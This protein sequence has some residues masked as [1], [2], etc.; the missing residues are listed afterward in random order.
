MN[1]KHDQLDSCK[2]T[3]TVH[4]DLTT[5]EM[6]FMRQNVAQTWRMY[7]KNW[8]VESKL[9]TK[10]STLTAEWYCCPPRCHRFGVDSGTFFLVS[11]RESSSMIDHFRSN[12]SP[13]SANYFWQTTCYIL[14]HPLLSASIR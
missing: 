4:Y 7:N 9:T 11:V 3:C 1:G 13:F 12:R 6:N 8:Y 2:N 5:N 10:I 14:H